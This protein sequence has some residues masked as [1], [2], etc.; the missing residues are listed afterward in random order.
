MLL[1]TKLDVLRY[2]GIS[3]N[4]REPRDGPRNITGRPI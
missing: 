1:T 2:T 4:K 3:E